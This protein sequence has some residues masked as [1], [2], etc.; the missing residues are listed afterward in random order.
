[1]RFVAPGGLNGRSC[2]RE[3]SRE[4]GA[5]PDLDLL[6]VLV[7]TVAAFVSGAAYYALLGEQL[8]DVSAAAAE[9]GP[10]AP[11]KLAVELVRCLV[12]AAVVTGL[13]SQAGVDEPGGGLWL[14]L[15]LWTRVPARAVDGCRGP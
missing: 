7:A 12:L 5:V 9:A 11:W 4:V 13:A 8:A 10:R 15:A 2:S 1:M 3:S 6:A 14:G